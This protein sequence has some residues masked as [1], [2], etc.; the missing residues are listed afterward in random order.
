MLVYCC[1]HPTMIHLPSCV[2]MPNLHRLCELEKQITG[3]MEVTGGGLCRTSGVALS[4][5]NVPV[6]V[7]DGYTS[8]SYLTSSTKKSNSCTTTNFFCVKNSDLCLFLRRHTKF[9]ENHTMCARVVAYFRFVK[10]AAVRHL[11]FLCFSQFCGK[12]LRFVPI[13]ASSCKILWKSDN[14]CP[15]YCIFSI[16]RKWWPSAIL[17]LIWLDVGPPV[18]CVC[19]S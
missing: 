8:A 18:T 4:T 1:R 6:R 19:W 10:M 12:K 13:S 17:D 9:G 3:S 11:G 5:S 15:S 7:L 16:C 14:V 2:S